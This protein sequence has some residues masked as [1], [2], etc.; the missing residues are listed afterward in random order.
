[1][2]NT[3][4]KFFLVS[5]CLLFFVGCTSKS[6]TAPSLSSADKKLVW[7]GDRSDV[8]GTYS[9][10]K[11]TTLE[12]AQKIVEDKFSLS[13]PGFYETTQKL[14]AENNFLKAYTSQQTSYDIEVDMNSL[15][16]Y[17]TSYYGSD[18]IPSLVKSVIQITYEV[19]TDLKQVKTTNEHVII[20]TVSSEAPNFYQAL[21]DLSKQMASAL[22]YKMDATIDDFFAEH[23]EHDEKQSLTSVEVFTKNGENSSLKKD[24]SIGY[25]NQGFLTQWYSNVTFE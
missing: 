11:I 13:L 14:L 5:W 19:D 17:Q 7:V 1:M 10:K 12:E 20:E 21:P 9:Y 3:Y 24:M 8:F 2:K 25:N 16:F 22:G 18:A 15:N 4:V 23:S 6:E